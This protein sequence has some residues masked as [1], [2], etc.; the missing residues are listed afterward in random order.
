MKDIRIEGQPPEVRQ[1]QKVTNKLQFD[2]NFIPSCLMTNVA[3]SKAMT[4]LR[5][6][7]RS[8]DATILVSSACLTVQG[9]E[10]QLNGSLENVS[11]GYSARTN[12]GYGEEHDHDVCN[13]KTGVQQRNQTPIQSMGARDSLIVTF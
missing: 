3:F 2:P 11:G 6:N 10:G 8:Y 13:E 7:Q 5:S 4:H 1:S 12:V 9:Q